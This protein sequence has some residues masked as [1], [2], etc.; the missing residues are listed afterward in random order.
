[1]TSQDMF[2]IAF[3]EHGKFGTN[4]NTLRRYDF[5]NPEMTEPRAEAPGL[6]EGRFGRGVTPFFPA[7][8]PPRGV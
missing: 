2:R 5:R 6:Y 8:L 4:L 3:F 7:W 1:M